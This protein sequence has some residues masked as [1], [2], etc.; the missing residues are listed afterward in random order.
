[1]LQVRCSGPSDSESGVPV[2]LILSNGTFLRARQ[3]YLE[4]CYHL[5]QKEP[6]ELLGC[7]IAKEV[8]GVEG[9]ST[10]HCIQALNYFDNNYHV[11]TCTNSSCG[12]LFMLSIASC[13]IC[14]DSQVMVKHF[15]CYLLRHLQVL[16][17]WWVRLKWHSKNWG[18]PQ[19]P[20]HRWREAMRLSWM[21]MTMSSAGRR[22]TALA[23]R[24][25]MAVMWECQVVPNHHHVVKWSKKLLRLSWTM[26]M[27]MRNPS[28][29]WISSR[30]RGPST[31]HES[32]ISGSFQFDV[33]WPPSAKHVLNSNIVSW[34][35]CNVH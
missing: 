6:Q 34:N 19:L 35:K 32:I 8:S 7:P 3:V 30:S 33:K 2:S 4:A 24:C 1:M 26:I 16:C 28:T 9:V 5:P 25:P 20:S 10:L 13:Q 18:T 21:R 12:D 29:S 11:I 15:F 23:F 31:S 14:F 27:K 22:M 17:N